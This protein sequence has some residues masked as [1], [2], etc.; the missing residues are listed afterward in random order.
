LFVVLVDAIA[1]ALFPHRGTT[2]LRGTVI[3]E[4][5][6]W[7]LD[8]GHGFL[9]CNHICDALGFDS[10]KLRQI[11]KDGPSP[12]SNIRLPRSRVSGSH[13]KIGADETSGQ[14]PHKLLG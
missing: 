11:V 2:G 7:L 10:A 12:G 8:E 3:S 5:R 9:S 4:A 13:H 14:L 1:L 6:E